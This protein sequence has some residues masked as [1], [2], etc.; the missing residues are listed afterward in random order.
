MT[1]EIN[2]RNCP[3]GPVDVIC[4]N[5]K[6]HFDKRDQAIAFYRG[7]ANNSEG[8][9]RDRYWTILDSLLFTDANIVTDNQ[10]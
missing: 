10:F 3:T 7:G 4:Y 5:K 9:E 1:K 8:A 6:K 2:F